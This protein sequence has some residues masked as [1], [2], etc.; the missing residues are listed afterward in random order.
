MPILNDDLNLSQEFIALGRQNRSGRRITP[1]FITIHNTDNTDRGAD[2]AAHS[3]FVRKTGFYLHNEKPRWV[4]WHFTVDDKQVIQQ[5][6]VYERA[7]HVN[8]AGNNTSLAI[9]ICMH[10]DNDQNAADQRAARL[11]AHLIRD[12]NLS[13]A[14]LRTHNSWT[15]KNC[16]RLI[17]PSW[18]EFVAMVSAELSTDFDTFE[19]EFATE[20]SVDIEAA[21]DK[22]DDIDHG[23]IAEAMRLDFD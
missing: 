9:E 13:I 8:T 23:A 22:S 6:P 14:D 21:D 12:H 11:A 5:L 19:G 1:K 20:D 17:L 18:N 4:S 3:S 7:I 15:G 2:A 16:P 10:K